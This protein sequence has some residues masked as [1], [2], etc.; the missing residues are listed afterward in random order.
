M[1]FLF[2]LLGILSYKHIDFENDAYSSL[3]S[4]FLPHYFNVNNEEYLL[5]QVFQL[6]RYKFVL[7]ICI[8]SDRKV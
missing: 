5:D 6:D 8:I 7:L 4:S 3:P 1:Q 2:R